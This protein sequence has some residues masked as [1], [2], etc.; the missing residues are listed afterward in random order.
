LGFSSL[1]LSAQVRHAGKVLVMYEIPTIGQHEATA[2]IEFIVA[3]VAKRD[4]AAVI[5]VA[6]AYGELVALL[7]M[8]R[9]SLASITIAQHKAFTAAR[10]GKPSKDIGLAAR[11]PENGFDI[12]Y[13]G[14]S[15]F[16]GFGGG[17]PVI[18]DGQCLGAI[19]ISGLPE[20]ED[21]EICALAVADLFARL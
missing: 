12:A 15:R 9:A 1:D 21:I 5:V 14:D 16:T 20:A 13:L 19:A 7:R 6:D 10:E 2:A 18:V 11:N 3:E 17:I 4:K 8:D